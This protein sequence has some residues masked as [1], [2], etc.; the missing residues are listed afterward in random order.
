MAGRRRGIRCVGQVSAGMIYPPPLSTTHQPPCL[1]P[2]GSIVF[3]SHFSPPARDLIRKLCQVRVG[4]GALVCGR[5]SLA[6]LL[7]HVAHGAPSG[8]TQPCPLTL[9]LLPHRWTSVSGTAAWQAAWATSRRT[10]GSAP[11]TGPRCGSAP[12]QRPSSALLAG[13]V[14]VASSAGVG[15]GACATACARCTLIPAPPTPTSLQAGA[16][17]ARRRLQLRRLFRP[18][19]HGAR[20]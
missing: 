7:G 5:R 3:P 6:R 1:P 9:P 19:P 15:W 18:W 2:Q 12:C 4:W 11:S 13:A 17:R 16:G 20:L 10:P 8:P 14:R